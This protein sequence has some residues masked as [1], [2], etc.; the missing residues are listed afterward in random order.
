[1]P[2]KRLDQEDEQA[3]FTWS[4]AGCLSETELSSWLEIEKQV[5][6]K[7][8]TLEEPKIEQGEDAQS[9]ASHKAA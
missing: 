3:C 9:G 6:A 2:V 5:D 7:M 4:D 8:Q 1:M